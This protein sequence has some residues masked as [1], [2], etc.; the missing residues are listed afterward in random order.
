MKGPFWLQKM[1]GL[2]PA[3]L[4]EKCAKLLIKHNA[5]EQSVM[6]ELFNWNK[7]Y[8]K[9]SLSNYLI[10]WLIS[11]NIW[12]CWQMSGLFNF[13]Y[14]KLYVQSPQISHDFQ[15]NGHTSAAGYV[16]ISTNRQ[17]PD[18]TL[19]RRRLPLP[20]IFPL[21]YLPDRKFPWLY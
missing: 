7:L 4:K 16:G 8:I 13:D 9:T 19:S 17:F 12:N 3:T 15:Y 10:N 2:G 1:R 11:F 14:W 18:R 20:G 6:L 21:R 5:K